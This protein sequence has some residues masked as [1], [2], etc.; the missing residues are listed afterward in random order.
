[1]AAEADQTLEALRG[2]VADQQVVAWLARESNRWNRGADLSPVVLRAAADFILE[3]DARLAGKKVVGDK[4]PNSLLDG[5][6]VRELHTIYPDAKL[7]FIVRDGRDVLVS[8]RF[9]NFID[10]PEHLAKKD[11]AIRAAFWADSGEFIGGDRSVFTTKGITQAAIGWAQNVTETHQ[12]ARD[13]FPAQY[14]V[15]RFED[16]LAQPNEQLAFLW[17]FL[18][19]DPAGLADV[20]TAEMSSNPDADWQRGKAGELVDSLEKGKRGSWRELFTDRDKQVFKEKAGQSLVDWNYEKG[21][22]W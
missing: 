21:L 11:R 17:E 12:V 2:L 3:R 15:L 8:H 7:V 13:L 1:L 14:L 19:V 4:S 20:V 6:A 10:A 22:D 5:Q 18:D 9:Q 16:L